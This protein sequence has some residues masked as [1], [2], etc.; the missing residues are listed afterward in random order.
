MYVHSGIFIVKN[1]YRLSGVL[2][3]DNEEIN[4]VL[5]QDD[6]FTAEEPKNSIP[7]LIT[8]VECIVG[9]LLFLAISVTLLVGPQIAVVITDTIE[10]LSLYED[11]DFIKQG[12]IKIKEILSA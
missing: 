9:L 1:E 12:L 11:I 8:Y 5:Y 6:E 3:M 7:D 2:F 10:N 4:E